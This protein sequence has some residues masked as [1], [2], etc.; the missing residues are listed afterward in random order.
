MEQ[1]YAGVKEREPDTGNKICIVF[2]F[3]RDCPGAD[4]YGVERIAALAV[5][6]VLLDRFDAL[7][8]LEFHAE[9]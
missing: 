4:I 8:A 9:P 2:S 3:C 1:T 7:S 5:L 6:A